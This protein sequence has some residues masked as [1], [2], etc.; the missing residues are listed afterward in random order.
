MLT[1]GGQR[2][3]PTSLTSSLHMNYHLTVMGTH[4]YERIVRTR[5]VGIAAFV[6]MGC[7]TLG[8]PTGAL[9]AS[10]PTIESESATNITS[11][12]ATLNAKIDT[13]GLYTGY[14][15]QIDTNSSYD[16]TQ[17]SCPFEFPGDAQ[18]ASI[19]VGEPLPAGLVEPEPEYIPAGS[20]DQTVSLDLAS[21]RATLRPDTTYHYRVI[22]STGGSA[23][24]QGPDQTFTTPGVGAVSTAPSEVMTE[25]AEATLT[26]YKLT[27]ALNPVG[28][29]TTYYFEYIGNNEVECLGLENCWS[30]TAHMGPITGDTQQQVPPIEVTGLTSGATYRYRLIASNA[31]GTVAGNVASFTVGSPPSIVSESVSHVTGQDA[32]L[33]AQIDTEGLETSYQFHLWSICGGKGVCMVVIN[34]PLPSGTLLGSFVDQSVS[35]DLDTAGVTLQPGGQYFYS[36]AATSTGGTTGTPEGSRSFI[37]PE[38]VVQPLGTGLS[39]TSGGGQSTASG[40]GGQSAGSGDS[41]SGGPS[42]SSALGVQ[43]LDPLVV[44]NKLEGLT[45]SQKLAKALMTCEKKP[46]GKRAACQKRAH[47]TYGTAASKA[48]KR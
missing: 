25:P 3:E 9:A 23:T 33:E 40:N 29:P 37:T 30:H 48:R 38:P 42:S 1:I 44:K 36:V 24:V 2:F 17:L 35:L 10:Q 13:G 39:P 45:S 14:W 46:K 34:Y 18:C 12:D 27:G 15:F 16:F 8:S 47:R 21:I 5:A 28:L 31:D 32:T 6:A 11:T 43:S 19:L 7:L 4:R 22:A 41:G 20:G 26:G